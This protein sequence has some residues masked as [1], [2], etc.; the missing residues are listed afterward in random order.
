[1][2]TKSTTR[3][4]DFIDR[5]EMASRDMLAGI[6]K[7]GGVIVSVIGVLAVAAGIGVF[8]AHRQTS[9]ETDLQ[10]KYYTL[11]KRY[12][13]TKRGF[14][15]AVVQAKNKTAKKADPKAD[16]KTDTAMAATGDLTKD[17]GTL[18]ADFEQLVAESPKSKAAEMA[19]LNVA[20]IYLSYG[21]KDK[22][23]AV[24][25]KVNTTARTND[26]SGALVVESRAS[27]MADNGDC[28][29]AIGLWD[30]IIADKSSQWLRDESKLRM[31]LCFESQNEMARAEQIYK[32]VAAKDIK[33][34]DRETSRDAERYLRLLKLKQ[35]ARGG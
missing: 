33:Q 13:E 16:T 31:G 5:F 8:W 25:Q 24:L 29:G 1:M 28:K 23:L 35:S 7:Q 27:L 2:N 12:L 11:E 20:Q 14:D 17:Y 10:A 34:P 32:E 15:E 9:Q 6:A 22:A 3:G 30:K 19:A 18:P 26:F 4:P 21:Q